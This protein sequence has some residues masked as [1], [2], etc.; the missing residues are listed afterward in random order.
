MSRNQLGGPAQNGEIAE[1]VQLGIGHGGGPG[2][3]GLVNLRLTLVRHQ[4]GCSYLPPDEGNLPVTNGFAC[5]ACAGLGRLTAG[6]AEVPRRC[7]RWMRPEAALGGFGV[8]LQ[9]MAEIRL[10]LV[11]LIAP[12]H[13]PLNQSEVDV[14]A[15]DVD[16]REQSTVAILACHSRRRSSVVRPIAQGLLRTSAKG[17]AL[18]GSVDFCQANDSLLTGAAVHAQ[19]VAV[20]YPQDQAKQYRRSCVQVERAGGKIGAMV[21]D[22]RW[23][24]R[25]LELEGN[26]WLKGMGKGNGPLR[27]TG[28]PERAAAWMVC[29]K[30][31]RKAS[32]VCRVFPWSSLRGCQ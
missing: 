4:S 8:R 32:K 11:A 15:V 6:C 25:A 12:S 31:P 10:R 28:L 20:A 19:R 3:E 5:L 13:A 16:V 9:P 29:G 18:L 17:P 30:G 1:A 27:G 26:G 7:R 21:P 22:A 23:V 14:E 2:R 24:V